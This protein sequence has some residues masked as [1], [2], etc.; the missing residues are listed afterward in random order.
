MSV[1]IIEVSDSL[2]SRAFA[3]K[4]IGW[5]RFKPDER[6]S[7]T[8]TGIAISVALRGVGGWER[9]RQLGEKVREEDLYAFIYPSLVDD[10]EKK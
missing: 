7:A 10:N 9:D 8:F 2:T 4:R 1:T 3:F 6:R 5:N